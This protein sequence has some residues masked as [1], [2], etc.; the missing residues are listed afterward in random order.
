MAP[1]AEKRGMQS[2]LAALYFKLKKLDECE[3]A[4]AQILERVGGDDDGA[5]LGD[6]QTLIQVSRSAARKV[7]TQRLKAFP[8]LIA[9]FTSLLLKNSRVH[10]SPR[11]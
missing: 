4:L 6:A 2:D 11:V 10:L 1:G 5:G 9:G 7:V 3:R 8:W